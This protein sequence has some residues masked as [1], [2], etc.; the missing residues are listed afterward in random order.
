MC[1]SFGISLFETNFERGEVYKFNFNFNFR[2][3]TQGSGYLNN[4][5][6]RS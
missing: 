5:K 1:F 2:I 4:K 6:K 3:F